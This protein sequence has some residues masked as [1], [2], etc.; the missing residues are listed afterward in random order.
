MTTPTFTG[1]VEGIRNDLGTDSNSAISSVSQNPMTNDPITA[2]YEALLKEEE[3]TVSGDLTNIAKSLGEGFITGGSEAATSGLQG[4]GMQ[5]ASLP[6]HIID[7]YNVL[8]DPNADDLQRASAQALLA[9]REQVAAPQQSGNNYAKYDPNEKHYADRTYEEVIKDSM[10]AQKDATEILDVAASVIDVDPATRAKL[11]KDMAPAMERFD[12]AW[13][14][15][16]LGGLALAAESVGSVLEGIA[17]LADNKAAL[18]EYIAESVGSAPFGIIGSTGYGGKIFNEAI[19]DYK[20]Q[21]NG[22]LPSQS[23]MQ[24]MLAWSGTAAGLDLIGDAKLVDSMKRITTKGA[25]KESVKESVGSATANLGKSIVTEGVTEAGQTAIEEDLS[26]LRDVQDYG[27]LLE[28]GLIGAASGGAIGTPAASKEL[29]MGIKNS[30]VGT[31]VADTVAKASKAAKNVKILQ[32]KRQQDKAVETGDLSEITDEGSDTYDLVRSVDTIV[33]RN[34]K[35]GI[36]PVEQQSNYE[37]AKG[38]VEAKLAERSTIMEEMQTYAGKELTPEEET[39]YSELEAQVTSITEEAQ[40]AAPLVRGMRPNLE[41]TKVTSKDV[42]SATQG[43][44]ETAKRVFGSFKLSPD[45]LTPEQAISI[46]D[47]DNDLTKAENQE[48]RSYAKV[49]QS[50][51]D[52]QSVRSN[53]INGGIDKDTGNVMM[54][55]KDYRD[56]ILSDRPEVRKAGHQGLAA[57]AQRQLTKATD[58]EQAFKEAQAIP[59]NKGSVKVPVGFGKELSIHKGSGNLVTQIRAEA[60]LLI[61][62]S[63][64]F[65]KVDKAQAEP[66]QAE[67]VNE[68]VQQAQEAETVV[69]SIPSDSGDL[70]SDTRVEEEYIDTSEYSPETESTQQQPKVEPVITEDTVNLVEQ[71]ADY[72][73]AQSILGADKETNLVAKYFVASNKTR[74]LNNTNNLLVQLKQDPIGLLSRFLKE[75]TPN[76]ILVS[77]SF[78]DFATDFET[79]LDNVFET[80]GLDAQGRDFRALDYAQ[81]LVDENGKLPANIK[82]AMAVGAYDW[83]VANGSETTFKSEDTLKSLL[84]LKDEDTLPYPLLEMIPAGARRQS[85]INAMGASAFKSLN[86]K[87]ADDA[88]TSAQTR[89]ETA[90][91][92]WMYESMVTSGLIVPQPSLQAGKIL[93]AARPFYDRDPQWIKDLD[94]ATTFEMVQLNKENVLITDMIANNSKYSSFTTDLFG[95]A[96][97]RPLPSFDKPKATKKVSRSDQSVPESQQKV[98]EKDQAKPWVFRTNVASSF[99]NLPNAIQLAIAGYDANANSAIKVKKAGVDGKNRSIERELEIAQEFYDLANEQ[100]KG[101]LTPFYFVHTVWRQGRMGLAT[102]FNPQASKI[103][104]YLVNRA[105]WKSTLTFGNQRQEDFFT[106]AIGEGFDIEAAK[107]GDEEAIRLTNE[108]LANPKIREAIDIIKQGIV[109]G[110]QGDPQVIADAVKIGKGKVKTYLSLVAMAEY[111]LAKESNAPTF[112]HSMAREVDGITNGV[113]ITTLQ[114]ATKH[115]EHMFNMLNRMGIYQDENQTYNDWAA[116]PANQDSYKSLARDWELAIE[117]ALGSN[118]KAQQYYATTKKIFGS[119]LKENEEGEMD[120]TADGRKIAKSPLM[121][122]IYGASINSIISNIGDQAIDKIYDELQEAHNL[123]DNLVINKVPKNSPEFANEVTKARAIIKAQT[124]IIFELTGTKYEINSKSKLKDFE[125]KSKDVKA[126]KKAVS[127]VYKTP[128]TQAMNVDYAT[129]FATRDALNGV[130]NLAHKMFTQMYEVQKAEMLADH[131]VTELT[132]AMEKQLFEEMKGVMPIV[133]TATSKISGKGKTDITLESGLMLTGYE[134]RPVTDGS[135]KVVVKS[136]NF[137][138]KKSSL[139]HGQQQEFVEPGAGAVPMMTQSID[140]ATQLFIMAYTTMLN[141]HDASYFGSDNF[142][143]DKQKYNTGFE[144]INRQYSIPGEIAQMFSRLAASYDTYGLAL[145]DADLDKVTKAIYGESTLSTPAEILQYMQDL[146]TEHD[147]AKIEILNDAGHIE[148]YSNGVGS[149]AVKTRKYGSSSETDFATENSF[150]VVKEVT[151]LNSEQVFDELQKNSLIK[152]DETHLE[153]LRNLL[154]NV[155]NKVI[156]PFNLHIGNS[157]ELETLGVTDG[158]DMYIVNQVEGVE[159]LTGSLK[160]SL[161]MS[162]SEVYIHELIH[163]ITKYGIENFHAEKAALTKL[164]A[165][166]KTV[167]EIRDLMDDPTQPKTSED[168][169]A[170]KKR[171][172]HIFQPTKAYVDGTGRARSNHLH[173]FVA[174][175]MTNKNF[176]KALSKVDYKYDTDKI[177]SKYM[178]GRLAQKIASWFDRV[179]TTISHKLLSTHGKTGDKQLEQLFKAFANVNDSNKAQLIRIAKNSVGTVASPFLKLAD[180]LSPGFNKNIVDPVSRFKTKTAASIKKS[181][182]EGKIKP[183]AE[184]AKHAYSE[185]SKKDKGMATFFLKVA[186]EGRGRYDLVGGLHDLKRKATM[187]IDRARRQIKVDYQTFLSEAFQEKLTQG[188]KEVLS[189]VLIKGDIVSLLGSFSET[190]VLELLSNPAKVEEAITEYANKLKEFKGYSGRYHR[191]ARNLGYFMVTGVPGIPNP[192]MNARNIADAVGS[193]KETPSFARQAEPV[194]DVLA[195]LYAIQKMANKDKVEFSKIANIETSR[196]DGLNGITASLNL[197]KEFKAMSDVEFAGNSR[198]LQKGFMADKTDPNID[199]RVG[200]K[201][202]E[203]KFANEGYQLVSLLE[204]DPSDP[205]KVKKYIYVNPQGGLPANIGGLAYLNTET[206]RGTT[207]TT[208]TGTSPTDVMDTATLNEMIA[209]NQMLERNLGDSTLVTNNKFSVP[210]INEA[211]G[212]AGYR[213]VMSDK[214]KDDILNRSQE[215]DDIMGIMF[216]NLAVKEEIRKQ[217][218]LLVDE[219]LKVYQEDPNKVNYVEVSARSS[220]AEYAEYWRLL[221]EDMKK[222]IKDVWGSDALYVSVETLDLVFGYHKYSLTN[223]WKLPKSERTVYQKII[224]SALTWIFGAGNAGKAMRRVRQ[225]ETI[226]QAMAATVKDIFVVKTGM[227]SLGN[228]ISNITLLRMMG[229]PLTEILKGHKDS[230]IGMR[231]YKKDL[232][233]LGQVKLKLGNAKLTSGMRE[234]LEEELILLEDAIASNPVVA[235]ADKGLLST[236]VEDVDTDIEEYKLR[237]KVKRELKKGNKAGLVDRVELMT[238]KVPKPLREFV[239]EATI[240]Q[241]SQS[242]DFLNDLAQYSDFGARYVLYNNKLNKGVDPEVAAGE[243]LDTFIDYDL[244]T[245]KGLQYLNDMGIFMFTKYLIRIQRIIYKTFTEHTANVLSI[246]MLQNFFGDWADIFDSAIGIETNP[247]T[248]LGNPLTNFINAPSDIITAKA[249]GF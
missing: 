31:K 17:A 19:A 83:L 128:L 164:W 44:K 206:S 195:S 93:T 34:S 62:A 212:I 158:V 4:S 180:N 188:Q 159:P 48:L 87:M 52:V 123:L 238:Q 86:I 245:Q 169:I 54:G 26:K 181:V 74:A 61:E 20:E 53:V 9:T 215:F 144:I 197:L 150:D 11:T 163:N 96:N 202:D 45:S 58:V 21:N 173:E 189:K 105:G 140:A 234:K 219:L 116:N 230:Y 133:N 204:K 154:L 82:T 248:R 213:Y 108:K 1:L 91:G 168:Y 227:V 60:N 68:P 247:I 196:T 143:A 226:M 70:G 166:A 97:E 14:N 13:K 184:I 242:Y 179:I 57:F 95:S 56:M 109:T 237:Q 229:I 241:G 111:E 75:V 121:T 92:L 162:A 161:R 94:P 25:A 222:K 205:S 231:K 228:I 182:Q 6:Q 64:E 98:L 203:Q 194:I 89:L 107:E 200:T 135:L 216:S 155:A 191:Q 146:A 23:D 220:N 51:R 160:N 152:D 42:E 151:K 223:M 120:V 185:I 127:E 80:I 33:K 235:L 40:R 76:A 149:G 119:F 142:E 126:I 125:L 171:W 177:E 172:E 22:Q 112:T 7:A 50:L 218:S 84:G 138:G 174:L 46:A 73:L 246:M 36:T 137:V 240:M 113:C 192:L 79:S 72:S 110:E 18:G 239:K 156:T 141:V 211:G 104:R 136:G 233:S 134:S 210:I 77:N 131:G 193:V 32:E 39:K 153:H 3:R 24:K 118:K 102:R 15:D 199:V 130:A 67:V 244:P 122:S 12:A 209:K 147:E 43:D 16:D 157:T 243:V 124:D 65:A 90:L 221:P 165:Q 208:N 71:E 115:K 139:S 207:L 59:G 99:F 10:K 47:A 186:T 117:K 41:E 236:I 38:Q 217:N 2:A 232:K 69:E 81:Y 28:S 49:E 201:E 214:A 101:I 167:V 178:L 129:S 176:M 5:L 148:Q 8:Q 198:H 224:V 114:F 187:N 225:G 132:V 63:K 35:E 88:P 66:T 37:L 145:D 190:E 249:M 30:V 55:V 29:A 78:K 106:L 170:A 85:M 175:G 183:V 100:S 103:H 27:K